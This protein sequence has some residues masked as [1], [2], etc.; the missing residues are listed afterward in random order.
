MKNIGQTQTLDQ[1]LKV[2]G[3]WSEEQ[4]FQKGQYLLRQEETNQIF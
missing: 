2:L 1:L 3:W 4:I